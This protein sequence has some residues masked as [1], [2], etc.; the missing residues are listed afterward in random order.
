MEM[1]LDLALQ[2]L[3]CVT[4]TDP[5]G[6]DE[7]Y[8]WIFF[9]V[10]DGST[11]RQRLDDPLLL[12]ANIAVQSGSGRPG[13]LAEAKASSGSDIH[14]P[15][16]VG[17]HQSL[18]RPIVLNLPFGTP[19]LTVFI[20]GRM[21]T[22]C[23]AI[24]EEAVPR[25]AIEAAFAA[26]KGHI[27]NR[28]NDFFNGLSLLDF[29]PD[30]SDPTDPIRR[31]SDLF[32]ERLEAL[33]SEI[34]D[35]ARTIAE[36][37]AQAWVLNNIVEDWWN[38][39]NW[40]EGAAAALDK[41]E[42]IGTHTFRIDEERI[43]EQS[44]NDN[45]QSDLRQAHINLGAAWY[46]VSG[47]ANAT[48]SF[49]PGDHRLSQLPEQVGLLGESEHHSL[50]VERKCVDPGTLVVVQRSAHSQ[51]WQVIVN[52]P[53][54][55]YRYALDGQVL[56]GQKGTIHISKAVSFPEFD[57]NKFY[58]IG[59]RVETRL[60]T[61]TYER[62]PVPGATQLE[63]IVVSNDSAD[64]NFDVS[65]TIDGVLPSGGSVPVASE[66][67]SI[68]GQTIDFPD[69]FLQRYI[70]CVA[71]MLKEKWIRVKKTIPDRWRTPEVAWNQYELIVK[72]LADLQALGVYD[73]R[74]LDKIKQGIADKL[75]LE[76]PN[77]R[78]A[79]FEEPSAL[80]MKSDTSGFS[81]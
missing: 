45:L 24:D 4:P 51:H 2:N 80:N 25:G 57:E 74:A 30:P 41:D 18:L 29:A 15:P 12:S 16:D 9:V 22:I 77:K 60:V 63:R 40:F 49:V 5:S 26:V 43:V 6:Q 66:G 7:P 31:A 21:I 42:P 62:L 23:S 61:L 67:L 53:F 20:P 33:M 58:F 55:P 34:S 11:V 76:I 14:I 44:L 1:H 64:G 48:V 8:L 68:V 10:A 35:E 72:Q 78:V 38:P 54:M 36:D 70:A 13:N 81:M 56:I 19:P 79:E 47:Y 59:A 52:Y 17:R 27:Q 39:V 75:K 65:L 73:A 69:G 37:T 3:H 50:H 28:L 71:Q 32:N 46:V